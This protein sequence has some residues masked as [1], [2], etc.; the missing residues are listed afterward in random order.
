MYLKYFVLAKQKGNRKYQNN[1]SLLTKVN[2]VYVYPSSEN[3]NKKNNITAKYRILILFHL[4]VSAE[5]IQLNDV[6][7]F[8]LL[9]SIDYM[10]RYQNWHFWAVTYR[11]HVRLCEMHI[12]IEKKRKTQRGGGRH[13]GGVCLQMMSEWK[14]KFLHIQE[15][16]RRRAWLQRPPTDGWTEAHTDST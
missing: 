11:D 15:K 2:S 7:F 3:K 14:R 12:H 1:V 8:L 16:P 4:K 10:N 9:F 6:S 13:Q 5:L